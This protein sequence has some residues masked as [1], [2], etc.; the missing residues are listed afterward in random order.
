MRKHAILQ[1]P[2]SVRYD[3]LICLAIYY[4]R[5]IKSMKTGVRMPSVKMQS[6]NLSLPV[7]LNIIWCTDTGRHKF[8]VC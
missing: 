6:K 5:H 7:K 2:L 8:D 3:Y 1:S 4:S